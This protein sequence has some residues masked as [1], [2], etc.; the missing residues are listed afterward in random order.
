MTWK[1]KYDGDFPSL[2]W[3]A[4]AWVEQHCVIPDGFN[5]GRPFK[6]TDEQ[7]TFWVHHYRLKLT[8]QVGQLAPAFTYRRS[9]LVRP[10]KW[11][12][13]PLV[14]AQVCVE[15]VGPALFAGWSS[16]SEAWVCAD[17]G[18]GC[19]WV[20]EYEPGEPMAQAWPTALIQITATS[21]DQTDNIYDALRPMIDNGPLHDVIPK[22]GE[23][24]IRLPSG[25]RIDTVTSNATSRLGQRVTFVPHDE[26]GLY[27]PASGMIKV[28]ET[29]RRGLA[30]MGGRST[31]TTNAWDPNENSYAQRTAESKAADVW[32]DHPLPPAD[33]RYSVKSERRKIHTF[34]YRGSH[35]VDLDSI[36]AEAAELM[37]RDAAQAER[38]FGNRASTDTAAAF[39]APK[40]ATLAATVTVPDGEPIA[41]GFDGARFHDATAL[42][43]CR[44]TDAHLF[45]PDLGDMVTIWER[46]ADA[47]DDWQ[48]NSADVKA[49]VAA[50]FDRFH[51]VRF[52]GDPPYWQEEMSQWAADH[53]QA[54]VEWW[55]N[56]NKAMAWAVRRFTDGM[57]QREFT[58]DGGD[59]LV[60]H[61]ANAR[62]YP[63]NV[64]DDDGRFMWSIRK[65]SP[66]SPLK[67][68]AAMAAILSLEARADALTA[69]WKPKAR[70][71]VG[72]GVF[73]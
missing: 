30:G 43:A 42:V 24:F 19:G 59:A 2:G 16:G 33:L 55:T 25:G 58:H 65:Q 47:G 54:V 44:M 34:N 70:R 63:L 35:W 67:I 18:C 61:I 49:A 51:V 52:Y 46:P 26:T 73:L 22:T 39:D 15:G 56:R 12:K 9:Q 4:D 71:R 5:A 17:H 68:D 50:A 41:L 27:L 64:R 40:F 32:R 10:Q 28:A 13:G 20:Y 36:E 45:T 72:R 60:R 66:K 7:L 62:K 23:S 29:Q 37:E 48:V 11:G 57:T 1:P 21:E 8:A 31:E 69:G 14:A 6:L 3:I 38:F 53:G